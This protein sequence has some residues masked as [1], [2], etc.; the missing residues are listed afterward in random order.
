MTYP[1]LRVVKDSGLGLSSRS[2]VRKSQP[3][4]PGWNKRKSCD[5]PV[6]EWSL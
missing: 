6:V 2:P 4:A 1:R 3:A 5:G